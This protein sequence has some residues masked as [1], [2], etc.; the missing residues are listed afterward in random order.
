MRVQDTFG[1][2]AEFAFKTNKRE[3]DEILEVHH[4]A[5]NEKKMTPEEEAREEEM[6]KT[7]PFHLPT[8][9]CAL[10]QLPVTEA[11]YDKPEMLNFDSKKEFLISH[12][13][14]WV[15]RLRKENDKKE[16]QDNTIVEPKKNEVK[17][18]QKIVVKC[19][20][21]KEWCS[22]SENFHPV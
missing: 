22:I 3:V 13:M 5:H 7:S 12:D 17:C 16:Y 11:D 10:P 8:F 14:F 19:L 9:E 2:K 1:M 20:F 21:I 15:E 18:L 4:F 6:K